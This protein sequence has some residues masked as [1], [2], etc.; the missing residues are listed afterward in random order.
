MDLNNTIKFSVTENIDKRDGR[1]EGGQVFENTCDW[2]LQ[3]R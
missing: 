1:G 3:M 2:L